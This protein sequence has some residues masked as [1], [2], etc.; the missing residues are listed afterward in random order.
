MKGRPKMLELR[1]TAPDMN[2]SIPSD[3]VRNTCYGFSYGSNIYIIYMKNLTGDWILILLLHL[4]FVFCDLSVPP[5]FRASSA[6]TVTPLSHYALRAIGE[7]DTPPPTRRGTGAT[8]AGSNRIDTGF[9]SRNTG[10]VS[11][12]NVF[13]SKPHVIPDFSPNLT[14][15]FSKIRSTV[16]DCS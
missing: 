10:F 4:L 13:F 14:D 7:S 8:V 11:K 15:F 5:S 2:H 12:S 6:A 16:L 3:T 1:G 9:F